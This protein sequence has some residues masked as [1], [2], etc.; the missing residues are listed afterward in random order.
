MGTM[1][2]CEWIV[3]SYDILM[4]ESQRIT[5]SLVWGKIYKTSAWKEIRLPENCRA[6]D[7]GATTFKLLYSA[8]HIAVTD[9]EILNYCLS[10]QGITRNQVD[11]SRCREALFTGTEKL[12]FYQEKKEKELYRMAVVGYLN[13]ILDNMVYSIRFEKNQKEFYQEMKKLY[14]KNVFKGVRAKI[15]TKDKIRYLIYFVCPKITVLKNKK[16]V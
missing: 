5:Y 7:D 9:K 2:P 16:N 4:D 15:S 10:P 11:E 12:K 1:P 3:T 14:R 6:Y 13:D 8:G